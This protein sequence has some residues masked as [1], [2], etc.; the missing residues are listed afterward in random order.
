M[1]LLSP[2]SVK[3]YFIPETIGLEKI[4][5]ILKPELLNTNAKYLHFE[6]KD[7]CLETG[8]DMRSTHKYSTLAT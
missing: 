8:Q 1:K 2:L 6:E 4:P 7:K 5:K 3:T